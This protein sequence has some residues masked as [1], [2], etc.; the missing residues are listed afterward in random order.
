MKFNNAIA[1]DCYDTM[2]PIYPKMV[3][4]RIYT[5]YYNQPAIMSLLPEIKGKNVLDAGCG[6]GQL[7]QELLQKGA[8]VTCTDVSEK[9]LKIA[10]ESLGP[11]VKAFHADLAEPFDFIEDQSLDVVIASLSIHYIKDWHPVFKEFYRILRPEGELIF[12]TH[13][14]M[15][16]F[17]L[18]R[19]GMYHEI[20]LIEDR[21]YRSGKTF[22]V[23]YYRRSFS[24]ILNPVLSA[25]FIINKV[26]EPL[27]IPEAEQLQPEYYQELLKKS[28]I[29][30]LR[31]Q[32]PH[33]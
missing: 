23:P 6:I 3:A 11:K 33:Q 19:T 1:E 8:N 32:K 30:L 22:Q 26:L 28:D 21:W 4:T 29:L 2:A 15:F 20:E 27:P 5:R 31:S 13:H 14:P 10:K 25:G 24:E 7:S 9:M 17:K 18:S 16:D 12:S